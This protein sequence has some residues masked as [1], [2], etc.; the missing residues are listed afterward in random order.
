M[1]SKKPL[2]SYLSFEVIFTQFWGLFDFWY[3]FG[4]FWMEQEPNK[5]ELYI[6]FCFK[7]KLMH[8]R[9]TQTIIAYNKEPISNHVSLSILWGIPNMSV[10]LERKQLQDD[11]HNNRMLAVRI[12][13][14]HLSVN[15]K[16]KDS[17]KISIFTYLRS[18]FQ[19]S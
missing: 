19:T 11:R 3:I 4:D 18:N 12:N 17:Y 6:L 15:D 1:L 5:L 8:F 14:G 7:I 10:F 13:M 2:N 9:L 16:T